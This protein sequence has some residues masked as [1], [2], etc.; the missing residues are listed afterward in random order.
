MSTSTLWH[1]LAGVFASA[2]L[3]VQATNYNFPGTLPASCSAANSPNTGLYNC[4][5]TTFAASE[6]VTISAPIPAT[7]TVTGPFSA[8][9]NSQINA[10]QYSRN[11]IL[12]VTG[13]LTLGDG[14]VLNA[15]ITTAASV[16]LGNNVKLF[17][18]TGSS[19]SFSAGTSSVLFGNITS[20]GA[21]TLGDGIYSK[22]DITTS[23]NVTLGSNV[24]FFGNI[25]TTGGYISLGEGSKVTGGLKGHTVTLGAS[26]IVS[27]VIL[28]TGNVTLG[29]N[30]Q[31]KAINTSAGDVTVAAS[32]QVTYKICNSGGGSISTNSATSGRK[33]E[34]NAVTNNPDCPTEFSAPA[35][36]TPLTL[37][38]KIS[39]RSWRQI[40]LR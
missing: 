13:D 16:L 37:S 25:T 19:Q 1:V 30:T 7:L 9:Q 12:N 31:V 20:S 28:A 40:F 24:I 11:L 33:I 34:G 14:A 36:A 2:C 39:T 18:N 5:A 26:S 29:D 10:L 23:G 32:A 38:H 4:S 15:S 17:G 6:L 22:G 8:V 35:A 27:D 21:V 3:P